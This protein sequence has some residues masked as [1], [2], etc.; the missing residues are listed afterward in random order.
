MKMKSAVM[1]TELKCFQSRSRLTS[2]REGAMKFRLYSS[3]SYMM[4]N[5]KSSTSCREEGETQLSCFSKNHPEIL[6]LFRPV[7]QVQTQIISTSLFF[8]SLLSK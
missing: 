2:V 3:T 5:A 4:L 8:L 6:L 7:E 1:A